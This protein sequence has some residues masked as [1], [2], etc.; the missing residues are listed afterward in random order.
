[1]AT[2]LIGEHQ[3]LLGAVRDFE[4]GKRRAQAQ[5]AHAVAALGF[6]F[7]LLLGQ[8]QTGNLDHVI[9]H[10]REDRNHFAVALP[11]KARLDTERVNHKLGQIDRAQQAGAFWRQG[12]FATGIR[13][14][15]IFA[16][17]VIVHAVNLVD[18]DKSGLGVVVGGGHDGVPQLP[19]LDHFDNAAGD[20][21]FSI[22]RVALFNHRPVTVD[23][24]FRVNVLF[25]TGMQRKGQRPV[26]I[27]FH[28]FHKFVG[29][30]QAK[31]KLTQATGFALG[32]N[33]RPYV[34]VAD[35]KGGH[36][37]ATSA[38]GRGNGETHLVVD[39]HKRQW[40]VGACASAKYERALMAQRR[41]IVADT[42][43]G[44]Q[45][46]TRIDYR[47][48]NIA[49]GVANGAG[50]GAVNQ[51]HRRL[52]G[53]SS[54]VGENT[55]GRNGAV[56]QRPAKF[57]QPRFCLLS[58]HRCQG[59]RHPF[60]RSTH[61]LINGLA[62]TI[63][64]T[65]FGVPYLPRGGLHRDFIRGLHSLGSGAHVA[66]LLHN[67]V[68]YRVQTGGML[69]RL[70]VQ[71]RHDTPL[72]EALFCQF[73]TVYREISVLHF[74]HLPTRYRLFFRLLARNLVRWLRS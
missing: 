12:L 14:A 8:R 56:F 35:I 13:R 67:G 33:K 44:F 2:H 42:G 31:V 63:L 19:R 22:D 41:E 10:T 68:N 18:Q 9:E 73:S 71:Y 65:V 21:A 51:A 27:V 5:K 62:M 38:T 15:D 20:A 23:Q 46:H 66:E 1:M 25:L 57:G 24:L 47:V 40:A 16:E 43:P 72:Y 7:A 69:G 45:R 55:P 37:G 36:L 11:V 64:E 29:N 61:V 49:H 53:L 50:N 34:R 3:R 59:A 4:H 17:P 6:D 39:I 28:R 52:V 58:L 54:R 30:Q 26:G 48:E 70:K 74:C 32:L 60:K